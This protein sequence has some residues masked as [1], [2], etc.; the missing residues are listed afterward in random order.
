MVRQVR[1]G[2]FPMRSWLWA[3]AAVAAPATAQERELCTE[4]PGLGTPPCTVAPG[5]VQVETALVDWTLDRGA[6]ARSDTI[7][8]AD[9]VVRVGVGER[10][11][12]QLGWTP[13]GYSRERAGAAVDRTTRVGDVMLGAKL[14][15]ASPDG[16][17]FSAALLPQVSLPIGRRP[18][19]AGDWST[20]L[21]V[22]VSYDLSDAVQFQASPEV[23]AAV[24]EDGRGRH[25]AYGG[26]VGLDFTLSDAFETALELQAVRDRDPGGHATHAYGALSLAWKATRALQFD[27]G[28]NLGLNHASD[29]VELYAGISRRF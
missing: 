3:L 1:R 20:R 5:R 22:P 17:G 18:I 28:A 27:V 19:G 23:D 7:L 13:A 8:F 26:T 2:R 4:R 11:E 9:T 10:A 15:L 25:L 21:L 16:S 24:D 14:S 6:G 12:V 29:D